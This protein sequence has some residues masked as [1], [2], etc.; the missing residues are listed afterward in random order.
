M[1]NFYYKNVILR[2]FR[3][4]PMQTFAFI[5][6]HLPSFAFRFIRVQTHSFAIIYHHLPSFAFT[7]IRVQT[8]S[9]TIIYHHLHSRLLRHS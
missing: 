6:V 1:F 9:F 2:C 8:R 4:T 5:R 7:F 3:V